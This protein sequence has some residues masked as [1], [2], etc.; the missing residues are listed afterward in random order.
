MPRCQEEEKVGVPG[1][2]GDGRPSPPCWVSLGWDLAQVSL[3]VAWGWGGGECHHRWWGWLHL[4]PF[5]S[6]VTLDRLP[7]LSEFS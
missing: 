5:T 6:C 3:L 4:G 7:S 2:H 1:A